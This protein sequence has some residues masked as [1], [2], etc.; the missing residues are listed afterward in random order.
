MEKIWAYLL[1][2]GFNMWLD[3][4]HPNYQGSDSISTDYLRCQKEVWNE[5]VEE[6]PKY[7]I[8]MVV[9]DIGEGIRFKSHPELAVKGAW[10]VETLREELKKMR[11]KGIEPIPKLNFSTTHDNWL[12][13]YS[14]RVSTKEYYKVCKDLINEVIEIF[15][16]PRFF[17]LGMDEET[18]EHQRD[19]LYVVIRQY[20]LWWEDLLYLVEQVEK[21]GARAWIWSDHLWRH[22]EDFLRKMPKSVVQSNWYYDR[23]FSPD[24]GYVKAYLELAEA[25]YEQ[26]PT[27]SNWSC[28][29]NFPLMVEFCK[30]NIPDD[31]LLGF[32][33]TS[34][35][36]TT[37]K[38]METH[39]RAL[40]AVSKG[41]DIYYN[42]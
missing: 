7:G 22:T 41:K 14:R 6:M 36:P 17:H 30:K 19:M 23:E 38:W 10:E 21:N 8:N 28:E 1:H 2:L 31:Y 25:K 29:E 5:L 12:R 20:D 13:D 24:I 18:Y 37:E 16:G 39:L 35:R 27:G 9:I 40:E 26:I 4:P 34:W 42:L 33:Q 15:D 32:L 3:W 11:D